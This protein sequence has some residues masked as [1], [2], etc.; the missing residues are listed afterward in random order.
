MERLASKPAEIGQEPGPERKS[1]FHRDEAEIARFGKKQRLRIRV[2]ESG[3]TNG[4]PSGI[5]YGFIFAWIGSGL[6]T[7]VMAEMASIMQQLTVEGT[8]AATHMAE[9]IETAS[10]VI[11]RSMLASVVLNGS[12]GFAIVTATLFCLGNEKEVLESPTG[13]P[14]IQ[15]FVNATGS[16][17]GSNAMTSII[18]AGNISSAVGYLATASR[19]LW[20][21]ARER[22][23]PG[24]SL[25]SRVE[26]R[27][28]LP[29]YSI[30]L[31]T[32][33]SLALA[34][35]NVGSTKAF[36]AFTSLVVAAF[37]SSFIVASVVLL[38]R[39]LDEKRANLVYGPFSLGRA[40]VPIIVL[41]LLYSIIGVF[42]SFWPPTSVVDAVTMNWSIAVFGGVLLFSLLFW[43]L[44][45][46]KVYTGP[47]WEISALQPSAPQAAKP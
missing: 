1:K 32:I 20:A 17:A 25:L 13:F 36:N 44:H 27:T 7:L 31:T 34:L 18:I 42:F 30:G 26:E 4:G 28:L 19:M 21:F 41:A 37:Y 45:G 15:V 33:I 35:I 22:G 9:E 38:C 24:S 43:G 46:R 8:D 2:L 14:F 3:L 40:G 11:P 12:L 10:I 5:I 47:I 39:K 16:K 6:Q 29:L 23:L